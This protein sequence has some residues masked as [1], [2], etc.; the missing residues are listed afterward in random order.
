MRRALFIRSQ[1][2][3]LLGALAAPAAA[4]SD[5]SAGAVMAAPQE[6]RE[7]AGVLG[8]DG[9]GAL[10][11][12]RESRNELI[13]LAD[14]PKAEGFSVAC[15]HKD[16]EPYMARGRELRAQGIVD[17]KNY[18]IRWAEVEKGT[19][20]MV[21]EPRTLYVLEGKAFDAATGTVTEEYR[22]WVFYWPFA[23][24]A[25]TGLSTKPQAGT[26]WLMYPGT[27]GAHIMV[28][29]PRARRQ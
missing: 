5:Q 25:M 29:P 19:L 23:T 11:T 12:L 27:A 8:Y 9:S 1:V 16:L 17:Q 14:D 21:R 6:L 13:C 3:I 2:V 24:A 26:P 20:K 22:R 18:D 10:V 4:Q 28:S 7:G 15:Y